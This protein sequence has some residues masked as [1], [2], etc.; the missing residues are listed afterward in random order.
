MGVEEHVD[1]IESNAVSGTNS[2]RGSR[3][4]FAAVRVYVE[5]RLPILSVCELE[6]EIAVGSSSS[7]DIVANADDATIGPVRVW[8]IHTHEGNFYL[9]I[10]ADNPAAILSPCSDSVDHPVTGRI[11]RG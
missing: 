2:S 1:R 3:D 4:E 9:T 6:G 11:Y 7:V 5:N 8:R 10:G